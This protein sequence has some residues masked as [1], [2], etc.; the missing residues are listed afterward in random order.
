MRW[1]VADYARQRAW[2][3]QQVRPAAP[4]AVSSPWDSG[5]HRPAAYCSGRQVRRFAASFPPKRLGGAAGGPRGGDRGGRGDP[6]RPLDGPRRGPQGHRR[7]RLVL[8][9]GDR[10]A[11]ARTRTTA[12]A[13]ITAIGAVTGNVKQVWELS[14]MQHVTVLAAAFAFS[15]RRQYAER[16]ARQLRSWWAQNPFLSGV[17]WT[18]G[19]EV[20]LRLIAWV[21]VRRLLDGWRALRASSSTTTRPCP[22]SGGISTTWRTSAAAAR[23]PTTT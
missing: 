8:R 17:H 1:R 23:P 4:A 11:S 9:P 3:L 5:S 20:G 19:I 2:I 12:S 15:A 14:R 16:A 21:W 22:R 18:S 10:Q 7:P 6:R 13:S